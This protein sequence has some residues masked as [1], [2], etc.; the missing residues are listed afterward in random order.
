MPNP[1]TDTEQS[2]IEELIERGRDQGYLL[3]ADIHDVLSND[4]DEDE[5]DDIIHNLMDL[6]ISVDEA[7]P[8]GQSLFNTTENSS[9]DVAADEAAIA[10]AAV[11]SEA[12]RT[13]DPARMYLREMGGVELLTRDDEIK[14][15]R[16]IEEGMRDIL[17]AVAEFPGTVGWL[18]EQ[19][20]NTQ[21]KKK[22]SD[23]LV[24]YLDPD[25]EIQN[26]VQIDATKKPPQQTTPRTR[27]P[28]PEIAQTR[29]EELQKINE[30]H[31]K[32]VDRIT[33]NKRPSR[34]NKTERAEIEAS[35]DTLIDC[36]SRFKL[37]PEAHEELLGQPLNAMAEV[38]R[39]IKL[40]F[41]ICV[42]ESGMP[43][44]TF[45]ELVRVSP[46]G[47][48][49][50][51]RHH[52]RGEFPYSSGMFEKKTE[53][54]RHQRRV[55]AILND[56]GLKK[57]SSLKDI[58]TRITKGQRKMESAKRQMVKANLRL[59]ISIAKKYNNRGLHFLDLI[60]EGNIGLMKAVDKFEYRRGYKFSTYAT[61]WIRQAI[62]RSI[63][64]QSRTIRI[65]VHMF[66]LVNKHN[67]IHRQL[68]QEL[69]REPT[70]DELAARMELILDKIRHIQGI[71]I[72]PASTDAPIGE[73]DDAS[74][75]D[76]LKDPYESTP[77]DQAE[78]RGLRDV[79][80][81]RLGEL[82]SREAKVLRMRF[83]IGQNTEYTL[84]EVGRVF[85]ITRERIRQ[86]E[87]KA[88]RHLKSRLT[89]WNG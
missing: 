1:N 75:G 85:N 72:Q 44:E 53:I 65:P 56:S 20:D 18:I 8:D 52:I 49:V 5:I 55:N 38:R 16:E 77:M 33:K 63:S 27:G 25:A 54:Y 74:L 51:M 40:L 31:K 39:R 80:H 68:S 4:R 71:S 76:F 89:D 32:V 62:T 17:K 36:F 6:G 26:P 28:D 22:L 83:G 86:I 67:R 29:F 15:A 48:L 19:Y 45:R 43:K 87:A 21:K 69:G 46:P 12:R 60:Q 34:L 81:E 35:N 30:I 58:D 11:T 3:I 57:F 9:D 7:A 59:V 10:L 47:T 2:P 82:S 73:D 61:W 79:I 14:I 64:D 23:L 88:L 84:E 37:T 70:L 78:T 24:G 42:R 50:E 13:T 41:Q 66:D